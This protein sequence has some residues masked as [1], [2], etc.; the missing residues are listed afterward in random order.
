MAWATMDGCGWVVAYA[1]G[2]HISL[3]PCLFRKQATLIYLR[4]PNLVGSWGSRFGAIHWSCPTWFYLWCHSVSNKIKIF[5]DNIWQNQKSSKAGNLV[6]LIRKIGREAITSQHLAFAKYRHT[7]F[8]HRANHAPQPLRYPLPESIVRHLR[9]R[10]Q[11]R[12][13]C[14]FCA[15]GWQW[16]RQMHG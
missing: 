5:G 11:E 9:R 1:S 15:I 7:N 8:W 4:H 10:L 3:S 12:K 2:P 6:R 16:R 14:S 13:L